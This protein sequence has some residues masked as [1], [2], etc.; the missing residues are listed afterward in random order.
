MLRFEDYTW[1]RRNKSWKPFINQIEGVKF[2]ICNPRCYNFSDLGTGKTLTALWAADFLRKNSKIRKVLV[3][4]P[5]STIFSVWC[6]EIFV[7]MPYASYTVA[8]G[9]K[10]ERLAAI[11]KGYDYT[12][13]NHDGI[14]VV[15]T[16][17]IRA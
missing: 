6:H 12:I 3:V 8:H 14:C 15:E 9:T 13:I 7:N 10:A 2:F 5:L 4:S 17:L 11:N 1:P 16:E